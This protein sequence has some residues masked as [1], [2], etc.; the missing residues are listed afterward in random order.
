MKNKNILIVA[1]HPD[2]E[3]LGCGGTISK[4][5]KDNSIEVIF[6][7][8]GISSRK[9]N[10]NQI[11]KRKTAYVNLFKFLSLPEPK[12]FGFPDNKMDTVPLLKIVKKIEKKINEF[13]PNIII[14]HYENCLNIDHRVTFEA[15][16]T[17]CRP[18]K[19]TCV[20]KILSFEIPSS[21]EW[22]L[23]KGK[24]F[25][26]NYFIDISNHLGKKLEMI[27]FYKDEL[28]PYPHS[29]SIKAIKSF[30]S[31]RGVSVGVNYAEA[32]YLN[33]SID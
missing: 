32:F 24:N 17:A 23:F 5:Q 14:T 4:L 22:A 27:K 25:Q 1:A 30:A 19:D 33:R 2:D 29:R 11:K 8:N 10:N 28:R 15:V 7:T 9:V 21:T 26:P 31:F 20:K 3:I 6:M 13:K 12:N 18:L 16:M